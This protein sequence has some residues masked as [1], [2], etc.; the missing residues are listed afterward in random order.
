M[1][2]DQEWCSTSSP[3]QGVPEHGT[4]P[5]QFSL[6]SSEHQRPSEGMGVPLPWELESG[7]GTKAFRGLL[8]S[9]PRLQAAGG[10]Q[11]GKRTCFL[12]GRAAQLCSKHP[13]QTRS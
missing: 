7:R 13:P 1:E 12:R 4:I 2:K 3:E 10:S 5:G 8:G 9:E 6:V 11:P